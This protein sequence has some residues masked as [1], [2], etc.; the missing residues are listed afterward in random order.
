MPL[1]NF[2]VVADTAAQLFLSF[3]ENTRNRARHQ[4]HPNRRRSSARPSGLSEQ[5]HEADTALFKLKVKGN[6]W[7]EIKKAESEAL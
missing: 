2:L 3:Q 1:H 6:P 7:K 5:P 4:H